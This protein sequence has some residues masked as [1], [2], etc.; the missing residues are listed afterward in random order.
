MGLAADEMDALG[1]PTD[2]TQDEFQLGD[3]FHRHLLHILTP[4]WDGFQGFVGQLQVLE[5]E[6]P[7][8]RDQHVVENGQGVHLIVPPR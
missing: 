1:N 5:I 3:V 6:Y 7:L 2:D 8:P 4:H